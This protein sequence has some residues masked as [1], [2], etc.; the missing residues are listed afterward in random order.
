MRTT[1]EDLLLE[2]FKQ[3]WEHYRHIE[4]GRSWL[5][6]FLYTVAL[7]AAG[8][9][10]LLFKESN[11]STDAYSITLVIAFLVGSLALAVRLCLQK[12]TLV[13][14]HYVRAWRKIRRCIYKQNFAE[15]NKHLD[16][17]EN[18]AAKR[19]LFSETKTINFMVWSV[20]VVAG[21]YL[22]AGAFHGW[23]NL[24]PTECQQ[25]LAFVMLVALVAFG[26]YVFYKVR[27]ARVER[28]KAETGKSIV[29]SRTL[30][31]EHSENC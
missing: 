31:E 16:V 29:G 28:Q 8:A 3:A 11:V 26:L 19:S 22:S 9:V 18:S 20:A 21:F 15:L 5:T 4:R 13:L 14:A 17:Y 10:M 30:D 27:N 12:Y 25:L 1:K 23:S 6:G 24:E 2:E 7:A